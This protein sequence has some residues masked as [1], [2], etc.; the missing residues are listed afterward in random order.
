MAGAKIISLV[1]V[2]LREEM[3]LLDNVLSEMMSE[4]TTLR[5]MIDALRHDVDQLKQGGGSPHLSGCTQK[6]TD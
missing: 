5:E 6:E 1:D 3:I 4:C 2:K